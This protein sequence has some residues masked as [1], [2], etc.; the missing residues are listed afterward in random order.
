MANVE[1][2]EMMAARTQAGD[3]SNVNSNYGSV[4]TGNVK[5]RAPKPVRQTRGKLNG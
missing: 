5:L 2:A 4:G 3:N 1:T